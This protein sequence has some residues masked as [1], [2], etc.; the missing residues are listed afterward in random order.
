[1][2]IRLAIARNS[3]G[4]ARTARS[5]SSRGEAAF[6]LIEVVICMVVA[7]IAIA[8]TVNVYTQT[9]TST[10]WSSHY[11]AA[12]MMAVG[13]LEQTRAAKYDP[14]GSPAVDE[15][16]ATN[17]PVKIDVLDVGTTLGVRTYGTNT[18]TVTQLS[19]NPYLKM[20]RVDCT[21]SFPRKG[22]FTN[23]VVTFRTANQ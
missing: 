2:N 5:V 7:M 17:F 18:T 22:R 21:W 13:G 20:I 9:A 4:K 3:G 23:T 15:L 10:E 16:Q 12:Q 14:R 1:M 8:G 19:V 11:L 6:T